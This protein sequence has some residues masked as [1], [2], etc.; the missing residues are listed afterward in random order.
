MVYEQYDTVRLKDGR[1]GTIM[2][3]V[4]PDYVIDVGESEEDFD[5][6]MAT[7]EEIEGKQ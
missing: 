3:K 4:G 5:T 7:P 2:D 1:T 6:I